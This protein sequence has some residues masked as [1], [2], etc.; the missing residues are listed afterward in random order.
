MLLVWFRDLN[1]YHRLISSHLVSSRNV[2]DAAQ[3]LWQKLDCWIVGRRSL[4]LYSP[5]WS[6]YLSANLTERPLGSDNKD[7]GEVEETHTHTHT[8]L[9]HTDLCGLST[10]PV[11][12]FD[13]KIDCLAGGKQPPWRTKTGKVL[14]SV[15]HFLSTNT[16]PTLVI[17]CNLFCCYQAGFL[18]PERMCGHSKPRK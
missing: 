9:I 18:K 13:R 6:D 7:V 2:W 12:A 4:W 15:N 3:E 1:I 8:P 17:K 14:V 5:V 10:M 16:S 11:F